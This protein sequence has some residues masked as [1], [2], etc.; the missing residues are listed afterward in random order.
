MK[1]GYSDWMLHQWPTYGCDHRNDI[2]YIE[3]IDCFCLTSLVVVQSM[4]AKSALQ[5]MLGCILP[6]ENSTILRLRL[7]M[8][9]RSRLVDVGA[10]I[11][12]N[13]RGTSCTSYAPGATGLL[14]AAD[15]L[16][17]LC[18]LRELVGTFQA[19]RSCSKCAREEFSTVIY[20]EIEVFSETAQ[21]LD[22]NFDPIPFY[23]SG[24]YEWYEEKRRKCTVL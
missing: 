23:F 18:S 5:I 20:G 7:R 17:G 10:C 9:K 11:T 16:T 1:S 12:M 13:G 4:T 3:E 15:R 21:G 19:R 6:E 14:C 2:G 8:S 22:L 24:S